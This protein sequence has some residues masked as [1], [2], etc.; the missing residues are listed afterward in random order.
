MLKTCSLVGFMLLFTV[1]VFAQFQ[2]RVD[3]GVG[4]TPFSV[5]VGD[6]NGDGHP[7]LAVTNSGTTGTNGVSILLGNGDGT[8]QTHVDY[9]AD[10]RPTSLV[11]ADFNR[12]GKLDLAIVNG[13]SST[14]SILLGNGD[15]TF[16]AHVDYPTVAANPQWLVAAD[17]NN[18]GILDVATANYGP[19][20]YGG[21]VSV[22][23]G[24]GDG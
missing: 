23:L 10:D 14:L 4:P 13:S 15:G 8:F 9:A 12:D 16:K 3:Y 1:R 22:F 2:P 19:D 18:D 21:S 5:A 6:F 11:A 20:Y 7:D 24:N 17:F